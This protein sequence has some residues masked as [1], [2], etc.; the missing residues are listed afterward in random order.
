VGDRTREVTWLELM[1]ED[2]PIK[3]SVVASSPTTVSA[4][5]MLGALIA[6]ERGRPRC[7]PRRTASLRRQNGAE[8][9]T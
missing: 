3:L 1:R 5:A 2:S 4:R 6:G 7:E 8:P 9:A